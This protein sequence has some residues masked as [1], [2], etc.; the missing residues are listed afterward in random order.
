MRNVFRNSMGPLDEAELL[1]QNVTSMALRLT[2]DEFCHPSV[3]NGSLH[4]GS[5]TPIVVPHPTASDEAEQSALDAKAVP[6]DTLAFFRFCLDVCTEEEVNFFGG[7]DGNTNLEELLHGVDLMLPRLVAFVGEGFAIGKIGRK[8]LAKAQGRIET[9]FPLLSNKTYATP[10][11][12]AKTG[13]PIPL[14]V[15]TSGTAVALDRPALREYVSVLREW[16][17]LCWV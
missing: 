12:D 16:F 11:A 14:R 7:R 4:G 10:G 13:D 9:Q 1:E 8:I 5:E 3:L 15:S 17:R 6:R 2:R